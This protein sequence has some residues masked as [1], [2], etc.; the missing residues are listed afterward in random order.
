MARIFRVLYETRRHE[1]P[2][3]GIALTRAAPA[4]SVLLVVA[5]V[6]SLAGCGASL[7]SGLQSGLVSDAPTPTAITS[8]RL[9]H[10][11]GRLHK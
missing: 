8:Y 9:D 3:W 2:V 1:G 10:A 6:T 5:G 7:N 11:Y 4:L